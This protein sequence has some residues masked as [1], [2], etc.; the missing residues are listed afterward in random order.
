MT[1]PKR[2]LEAGTDLEMRLLSS[3]TDDAPSQGLERRVQAALGIGSIALGAGTASTTAA[4]AIEGDP[5]LVFRSREVGRDR[6]D[7]YRGRG[8]SCRRSP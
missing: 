6:G 4:A 1:D 3:A 2:L 7:R 8:G 5:A